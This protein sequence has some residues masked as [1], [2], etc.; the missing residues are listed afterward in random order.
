MKEWLIRL[1]PKAWRERYGVEFRALLDDRP[2]G[3]LDMLDI[4]FNAGREHVKRLPLRTAG[5]RLGGLLACLSLLLLVVGFVVR[6]EGAA[7]F[8]V[9]ASPL[10]AALAWPALLRL[11]GA[12]WQPL[13]YGMLGVLLPGLLLPNLLGASGQAA[14][15]ILMAALGVYGLAALLTAW[16][17]RAKLP[18]LA[19]LLTA[20]SGGATVGLSLTQLLHHAGLISVNLVG[21]GVVLWAAA[22]LAWT[23]VVA[24]TLLIHTPAD[25]TPSSAG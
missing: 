1:Y 24:V 25:L 13:A 9:I 21:F 4:L 16:F 2:P 18:A 14:L 19:A 20:L 8:F 15:M 6:E 17:A 11:A 10:L 22:H 7:E 5:I 12:R 23:A 3:P